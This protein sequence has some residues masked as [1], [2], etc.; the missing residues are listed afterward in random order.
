ART[1]SSLR[2]SMRWPAIQTSP[3][4]MRSSPASTISMVDLPEPDG[5]T[6]PTVS[7]VAMSRLTPLSTWTDDAPS[8]R[9]SD[10]SFMRMAASFTGRCSYMRGAGVGHIWVEAH[11]FQT[12]LPAF[13]GCGFHT[14]VGHGG[15]DRGTLQNR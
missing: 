5:P 12:V 1:T 4:S 14:S 15:G 8:P 7:P 9:V 13:A 2:L 6:T 10:T 3:A 11:G